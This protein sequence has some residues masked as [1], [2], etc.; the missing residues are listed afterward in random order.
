MA[1]EYLI[2]YL[3]IKLKLDYLKNKKSFRSEI[4]TIFFVSQ[5]VSF[6]L[7]KRIRKIVADTTSKDAI[8]EG[9]LYE[10]AKNGIGIR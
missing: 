9:E 8:P 6:R 4:K 3:N 5:V 10:E 1:F 7:A 2:E